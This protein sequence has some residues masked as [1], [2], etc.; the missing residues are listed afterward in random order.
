MRGA[1]TLQSS[2]GMEA[3]LDSNIFESRTDVESSRVWQLAP[4]I[5]LRFK[6]ARSRLEFKY[7]GNYGWYDKSNDDDYADH[8]FRAGAY[9]L[10]G[11]RTGLDLVVS[12]DEAHE[13]RGTGLST[14][15]EP[16]SGGFP[17]RPDRY[18][19]RQYLGRYTYGVS[20]TRAFVALEGSAEKFAYLNNLPLTQPF[21]RAESYGQA[22]F[23]VRVR[24]KTSLELSAQ[25]R[26]ITYD[27]PRINELSLDSREYRYLL[28]IV[29]ETTATTKGFVRV[30]GVTRQF[31][32]SALPTFSSPYWEV[33]V[34]WSP[35]TYSHFDLSTKRYLAEPIN[36]SGDVTDSAAYLLSWSHAWNSRLE[37]KLAISELEQT[38]RFVTGNPRKDSS[39]QYSL[40]LIY[41]MRSW[42]RWEAEFDRGA[43]HSLVESYNYSQSIA[44]LGAR[45]TF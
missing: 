32:D 17:Q 7:K 29:W 19:A 22:T 2:L 15:V 13:D 38:Y 44:R 36:L 24:P 5:L 39:R 28:G 34:R 6:P 31:A 21:D 43:R 26:D 41:E 40:A 18:T 45:I 12:Y 33:A 35:R 37:S 1:F 4:S 9:L 27:H 11:E 23:G 16:A 14:G 10:L 25:L 3:L 20:R 30:G 8:A 42:L